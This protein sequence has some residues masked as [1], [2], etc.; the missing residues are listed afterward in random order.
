M[1]ARALRKGRPARAAWPP[2]A[3]KER[4][5]SRHLAPHRKPFRTGEARDWGRTIERSRKTRVWIKRRSRLRRRAAQPLCHGPPAW[6]RAGKTAQG[7]IRSCG[8]SCEMRLELKGKDE[9]MI[10]M[11]R[12]KTA[13]PGLSLAGP[14]FARGKLTIRIA[15]TCPN[16]HH[17]ARKATQHWIRKVAEMLD[18]TSGMKLRAAGRAIVHTTEAPGGIPVR[19]PGSET[20]QAARDEPPQRGQVSFVVLGGGEKARRDENPDPGNVARAGE[21]QS[22]GRPVGDVASAFRVALAAAVR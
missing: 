3:R 5:G 6:T 7:C 21:R 20:C 9:G 2:F 11:M 19:M 8:I 10:G 13:A 16:G 15:D 17:I 22:P 14:D 18:H 4:R 1:R 12:G